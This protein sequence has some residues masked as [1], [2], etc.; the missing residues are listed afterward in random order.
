[1]SEQYLFCIEVPLDQNST[2]GICRVSHL[3]HMHAFVKVGVQRGRQS[4]DSAGAME[5]AVL[6]FSVRCLLSPRSMQ[7][8]TSV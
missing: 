2:S 1:M 6:C 7:D 4:E 8:G 3:F 5:L